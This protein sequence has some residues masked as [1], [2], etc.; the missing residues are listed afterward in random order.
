MAY[1][2]D[3]VRRHDYYLSMSKP[4]LSPVNDYV[5]KRVFGEHL[6]VLADL[7]QAVLAMPVTEKGH[8]RHRT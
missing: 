5:F 8:L 2:L 1:R 6:P 3:I 7:L 4:L